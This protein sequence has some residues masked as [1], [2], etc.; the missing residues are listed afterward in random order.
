MWVLL[1]SVVR[2]PL[3]YSFDFYLHT[4]RDRYLVGGVGVF[5]VENLNLILEFYCIKVNTRF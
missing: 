2:I 4:N 5:L 1:V 3:V